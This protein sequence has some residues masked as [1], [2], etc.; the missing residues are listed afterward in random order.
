MA[1]EADIGIQRLTIELFLRYGFESRQRGESSGTMLVSQP[2]C[3]ALSHTSMKVV[4]M[5]SSLALGLVLAWLVC[6]V[7]YGGDDSP[8]V[9]SADGG[10][11]QPAE[12]APAMPRPGMADPAAA[13]PGMADPAGQVRSSPIEFWNV[14][15]P[16]WGKSGL[17]ALSPGIETRIRPTPGDVSFSWGTDRPRC[18]VW[19]AYSAP[20]GFINFY[21][22]DVL[23]GVTKMVVEDAAGRWAGAATYANTYLHTAKSRDV[24]LVVESGQPVVCLLYTSP[25]PRD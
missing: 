13:V 5:R 15:G 1:Y 12:G 10:G 9:A 22:E 21:S 2:V 6:L 8:E 11:A 16:S 24:D 3:S 14:W 4:A 23:P 18:L 25:S 7:G 19:K 17:S 20:D